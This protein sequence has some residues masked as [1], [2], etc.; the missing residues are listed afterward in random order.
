MTGHRQAEDSDRRALLSSERE[1]RH[2]AEAIADRLQAIQRVT[3]TALSNLPLDELLPE[4]LLRVREIVRANISALLLVSEDGDHLVVNHA[5]GI[6]ELEEGTLIPIG[7]G[8][9]GRVAKTREPLI[10]EDLREVEVAHPA[11]RKRDVRSY[12]GVPL[13]VEGRL[14]GVLN[15]A[16]YNLRSFTSDDISLLRLV[17]DRVAYVI[18][19]SQLFEVERQTRRSAER[20]A[21]RLAQLQSLTAGLSEALTTSEMAT[22]VIEHGQTALGA[23]AG[24]IFFLDP[25]GETLE[26]AGS[27]GYPDTMLSG[28]ERIPMAMSLPLTDA[29]REDRLV[30]LDSV[31]ERDRLY[32]ELMA[33]KSG[34][35]AFVAIPLSV[36]SR[37]LG[38]LGL[39]FA[40]SP[41]F[42]QNEQV[43][44]LALSQQCAQA[45]QRA[46]LFEAEQR[47][48]ALAEH[49]QKR[50]AFL[51]EASNALSTSLDYRRTLA[52]VARL[53]VP[54]V[55]DWCT[56]DVVEDDQSIHQL[57]V[58][59]LDPSRV[60]LAHL[61]HQRYPTDPNGLGGVSRVVR[62]GV[63]E[64]IAEITDEMLEDVAV[65]DEHLALLRSLGMKSMMIVPLIAG[66]KTMGAISFVATSSGQRFN[67]DD[68]TL[69]QDL[70]RR[71]ALAMENARLYEEQSHVARTLQKSLLPP[72]MPEIPGLDIAARYRPAGKGAQV[73]GDFYDAFET[74]DGSWAIVVGDVCGKGAGASALTGLARHTLKTAALNQPEPARALATLNRAILREGS[75]R[76]L[77]R[78]C[79]L[80]YAQL[81]RKE[82]GFSLWL[83]SAGH[84]LPYLLR[85]D[86]S[87][88]AIGESGLLLGVLD[89]VHAKGVILDLEP[90][91][92][93]FLYTDGVTEGR[94][95]G[96]IFGDE[97]LQ[98]VLA[99]CVGLDAE[100]IGKTVE[101]TVVDFWSDGSVDDIAILV[102]KVDS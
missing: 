95:G 72:A 50:L 6:E 25:A 79:T 94:R 91:D 7:A 26:L 84:P 49:A 34:D 30:I 54:A 36:E 67:D 20:A 59:H 62:S 22:A 58:A 89:E 11:I 31:A 32:P 87:V 99:S 73:G 75:D 68:L 23:R 3:D 83:T 93:V 45:M 85:A 17:A 80:A 9:S 101:R 41:S 48:R 97:R 35:Q 77:Q 28:W 19:R 24:S 100:A 57:A 46:N 40:E 88:E 70:A 1:A 52:Q 64:L 102:V 13:V 21:N 15:A 81:Q 90:G 4:L 12:A 76:G 98:Q 51:A 65:E 61:L 71:A 66:K 39:S 47:A 5:S 42:S 44:M 33:E 8:V 38:V 43:F 63:P 10:V 53:A 27:A 92:A 78:F 69:A 74:S 16:T 60:E 2:R 82:V 86:G 14:I 56:V 18:D 55:A 37:P 29:V 96:D